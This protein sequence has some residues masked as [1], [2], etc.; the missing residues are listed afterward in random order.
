VALHSPLAAT[1]VS[2]LERGVGEYITVKVVAQ[3]ARAVD[4]S[5]AELFRRVESSPGY[6]RLIEQHGED[7]YNIFKYDDKNNSSEH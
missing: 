4:M 2:K 6:K 3:A 1:Q 7:V 5:L